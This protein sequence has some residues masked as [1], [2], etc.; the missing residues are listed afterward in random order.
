MYPTLFEVPFLGLPVRG[1][2]LMLMIAFLGGTWWAMRRA[3]RVKADPD[4]IVNLGFVALISSVIGARIF[5]VIHYWER[6]EGRGIWS[7]ANLTAGGLEFY[8]GFIGA[9]V[10]GMVYLLVKR[11]SI[12]LYTDIIAPSLMFGM[13]MARIGCFLNGCCWGAP[14]GE[15]LPWAV[16]FP[17][18]SPAHYRQ[19]E[20]RMAT[21]PAD[22]IFI[23]PSGSAYP[24]GRDA[25]KATPAQLQTIETFLVVRQELN[26]ARQTQADKAKLS[27][28]NKKLQQVR[29]AYHKLPTDVQAL[30]SQAMMTDRE[31]GKLL[32]LMNDRTNRSIPVHPAQLYSSLDGF[33]M[34]LLLSVIFY[35]RKRHGVVFGLLLLLYPFCRINEEII[36]IDNP[37]DTAGLTISQFVSLMIALVGA[38]WLIAVYRMPLRSPRAI[39]WVPPPEHAE[40]APKKDRRKNRQ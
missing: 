2:G 1:Y 8:G 26:T 4:L 32:D 3:M 39:P 31:P 22:L 30:G 10:A 40:P 7:I 19:W 37:H 21:L 36:R 24:L 14:C 23:H 25:R 9:F 17:Y 13:G 6:F 28:L 27:Q 33:V 16:Q 5:F 38:I 15:A 18:A 34:A 20:E 12:R 29:Q 11:V 35:R